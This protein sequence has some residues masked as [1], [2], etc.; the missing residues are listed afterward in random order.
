MKLAIQSLW[1]EAFGEGT[2]PDLTISGMNSG[3]N[4]GINIIYSGTVAAAI[5]SA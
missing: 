1:P 2:K 5:E 3:S 4:V